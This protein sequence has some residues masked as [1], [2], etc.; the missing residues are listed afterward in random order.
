MTHRQ[1]PLAHPGNQLAR[2]G[3]AIAVH[4]SAVFQNQEGA[5]GNPGLK[6]NGGQTAVAYA[7]PNGF[8]DIYWVDAKIIETLRTK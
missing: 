3:V 6:M 2:Y 8:G 1:A 5:Q 4:A 7:F